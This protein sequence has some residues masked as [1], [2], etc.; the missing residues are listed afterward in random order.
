MGMQWFGD[1]KDNIHEAV[2]FQQRLVVYYFEGAAGKGKLAWEDLSSP[3]VDLWDGTGLGGSQKG[4]V[5]YLDRMCKTHGATFAYDEVDV[6]DFLEEVDS[7]LANTSPYVS[8][9][10]ELCDREFPMKSLEDFCG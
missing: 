5:A 6:K 9:L 7:K 4:E 3:A 8:E 2:G 1:W 10:L